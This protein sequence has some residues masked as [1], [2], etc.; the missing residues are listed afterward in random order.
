MT[1]RELLMN[2]SNQGLVPKESKDT[3]EARYNRD[4]EYYLL[5]YSDADSGL[6]RDSS[7]HCN[8]KESSASQQRDND[9]YNM[10]FS[11]G[12]NYKQNTGEIQ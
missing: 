6:S 1:V 3:K 12:E 5:G 9:C 11:S 10:G 8:S 4:K 2:E 7:V